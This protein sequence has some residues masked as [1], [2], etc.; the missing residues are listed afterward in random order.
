VTLTLVQEPPVGQTQILNEDLLLNLEKELKAWDKEN[1]NKHFSVWRFCRFAVYSS[2]APYSVEEPYLTIVKELASGRTNSKL[3][4]LPRGGF[5]SHLIKTLIMFL[6]C[7]PESHRWGAQIRI[8]VCGQTRPFAKR[9]VKSVRRSLETNR[10]V[11]KNYR[12]QKPSKE[13][14]DA[15]ADMVVEGD[16][17][18][19]VSKPEWRQ[20]LFRTRNCVESEIKTGVALEEP[21]CWAQGMDES[22]TGYHMDVVLIDDPVGRSTWNSPTKKEKAREVHEDLQ[23]QMTRGLEIVL[24]TRWAVD[25]LHATI[26]TEYRQF[27]DV[28]HRTIWGNGRELNKKDFEWDNENGKFKFKF[29]TKDIEIFYNAYGCIEDEVKQGFRFSEEERVERSLQEIARKMHKVRP[30]VWTKQY[31][32][33]ANLDTD[34][35]FVRSW[36]KTVSSDQVPFDLQHYVLTD[37]ATGRD[38]RSSYRVVA[39]VGLSTNRMYY[40]RDLQFGLWSPQE[41]MTRTIEAN[42]RYNAKSVLLEQVAWQESFRSV[43][44]LLCELNGWE[45]PKIRM[46]RGRSLTSKIE[47]IERLQP[48]ICEGRM[49]FEDHLRSREY[50]NKNCFEEIIAEFINCRDEESSKGL[51]LDIPDA[52][53]DVECTDLEGHRICRWPKGTVKA[54]KSTFAE[55]VKAANQALRPPPSGGRAIGR[56]RPGQS[57]TNRPTGWRR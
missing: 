7:E 16:S 30:T 3:E 53:S 38:N 43:A 31:L 32:N 29:D 39:V 2:E 26:L 50:D 57:G 40:V 35:T 1:E 41:Y 5:K 12:T 34:Q 25:D 49:L 24:G 54:V 46:V 55:N 22:S 48:I 42:T 56:Q 23:S 8:C 21:S 9:T 19:T 36:F 15:W 10:W 37:S 45:M 33:R 4:L 17:D 27:Y 11:V 18:A 28:Q 51:R 52:L 47:R 44:A 6:L 14:S 13:L 20:D